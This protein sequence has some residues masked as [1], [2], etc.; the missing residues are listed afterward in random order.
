MWVVVHDQQILCAS[1]RACPLVGGNK[2]GDV[3]MLQQRQPVDGAFVEEVLAVGCGEHLHSHR[4]LVQRAAVDG[5][6]SATPNQL[7]EVKRKNIYL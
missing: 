2:P 7:K 5:A 3:V 4:P 6:I 1:L